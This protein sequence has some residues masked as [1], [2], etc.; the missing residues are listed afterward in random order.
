MDDSV[1]LLC[2]LA[3]TVGL[4]LLGA[5]LAVVFLAAFG[6][7]VFAILSTI[8]WAIKYALTGAWDYRGKHAARRHR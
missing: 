3:R 8:G 6:Y 2:N 7:T 5:F 4:G 1:C